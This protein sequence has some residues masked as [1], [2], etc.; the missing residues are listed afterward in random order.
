MALYDQEVD[1]NNGEPNYQELKN[2]SETP[3][4]SDD[5]TLNFRVGSDVVERTSPRVNMERKPALRR[6]WE[7]VF[8]GRHMDD[9]P[10]ETHEVSVITS[11]PLE[12]VAKVTDEKGDRLLPHPVRRRKQTDGEGQKP[13]QGSGNSQVN[14]R[15]EWNSMPIQIL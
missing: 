15:Q 12:T 11:K 13:S 8:S 14:S 10:K 7:S 2:C 9:V 4:W 1:R 6:K 5:H 3:H